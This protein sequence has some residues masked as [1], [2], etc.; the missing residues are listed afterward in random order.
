MNY[1]KDVEQAFTE[2]KNLRMLGYSA[3]EH[4]CNSDTK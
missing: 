2:K 1:L 4:V 3:S